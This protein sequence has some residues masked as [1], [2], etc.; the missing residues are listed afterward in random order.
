[1]RKLSPVALQKALNRLAKANSAAFVQQ[2]LIDA[3]CIVV[4]GRTPGE[5]DNDEFIDAVGGGSG[6]CSGM[7]VEDFDRSMQDSIDRN[8]KQKQ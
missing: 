1:M 8:G 3:H 5:I 6:T 2:G 7:S 4:Y